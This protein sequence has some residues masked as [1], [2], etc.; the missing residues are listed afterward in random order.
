MTEPADTKR[1]VLRPEAAQHGCADTDANDAAGAPALELLWRTTLAL[2]LGGL[3]VLALPPFSFFPVLV[4]AFGGF[5]L[6]LE[7][8]A[9]AAAAILG[10]G[11][12]FGFFV[13]G[14]QWIAESLYVDGGRLGWLAVPAVAG[15][16]GFLALFIAAAAWAF[17]R[18]RGRGTSG[19]LLFAS[20]W[21]AAE[22]LR[23]HL[24]TGFPWNLA[25]YAWTDYAAP[26]QA[27]AVVGS[28]GLSLLTVLAATLPAVAILNTSGRDRRWAIL[29]AG[30]VVAMLLSGS[31]R[32]SSDDSGKATGPIVRVV[33]GNIAQALK[34]LPERRAATVER[35]LDLSSRP[36]RYDVL[37]WPETAFPG[38]LEENGA[39]LDRIGTL[40]PR[41]AHLLAG[42][43]RRT[44]EPE[45]PAYWNSIAAVDDHGR[46]TATYAK[47]HLVPFGEYV[48]WRGVLPIERLVAGLGDFSAG[49]GPR[50]IPLG[51]RAV[52]LSICYEA[53]FPGAV[54][55]R[56]ERPTWIFNATND[57]WFGTSIGPYQHLAS[58]RMRALS[59]KPRG[60]RAP[61][62]LGIVAG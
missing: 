41:G 59:H 21:T 19:A 31:L 22:W 28:Y 8:V 53:I 2:P 20:L 6:L 56:E 35:Y 1:T 47:H 60:W 49:P 61:V 10:W 50:T 45:G 14:A 18:L 44:A 12:G 5:F 48:P 46:I 39:V 30:I 16:S 54:V 17:A 4:L 9:P 42:T 29:I 40:L 57:A 43:P 52:G 58:A 23:G 38:F 11:F 27:A 32:L 26:R 55:D 51:G 37:L 62:A 33:Q 15:L 24:L 36:G 34:W 3:A 25:A 13:T 7:G